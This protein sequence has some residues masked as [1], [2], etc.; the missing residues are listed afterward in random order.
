MVGDHRM[1]QTGFHLR[2]EPVFYRLI[3]LTNEKVVNV[4]IL[5]RQLDVV[6]ERPGMR[7]GL[8]LQREV[9]RLNKIRMPS[10]HVLENN[11]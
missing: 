7:S 3:R 6:K 9:N 11:E 8:I 10:L 1:F 5:L 2:D 4:L